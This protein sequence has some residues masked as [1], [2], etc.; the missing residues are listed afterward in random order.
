M[1]LAELTR[2]LLLGLAPLIAGGALARLGEASVDE[3]AQLLARTRERLGRWLAGRKAAEAALALYE[4]EPNDEAHRI[5]LERQIVARVQNDPAAS[6]ELQALVDELQ[7]LRGS[8]SGSSG[9]SQTFGDN[10]NI[11]VNV[12]GNAQGPITLGPVDQRRFTLPPG[13]AHSPTRPTFHAPAAQSADL[14]TLSSDGVH[15]THGYALLIGVGHYA[16]S[17]LSVPATANDAEQLAGLLR[18]QQAAAYL[19]ERVVVLRDAAA[20]RAAI[21]KALDELAMQSARDPKATVLVFFAG[22]GIQEGNS[23]YLLPHDYR[24]AALASSAISASDFSERLRVPAD[25]A[26]RLLVLLNC[27]HAG[28]VSDSVLSAA[29]EPAPSAPPSSFL[30]PLVE[31]GGRVVISSSRAAERSGTWA[32]ETV[33]GQQLLAALRGAAPG[34]SAGIGVLELFAYLS[35]NVPQAARAITDPHTGKALEQHP[36]LYAQR[37]DHDFAIT[38]RPGQRRGGTMSAD[39]AMVIQRLAELEYQLAVYPNEQSAPLEL[40]AKRDQL[41]SMMK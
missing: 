6:A 9:N 20:T 15:F 8:S 5:P 19:P 11:G 26:A 25:R 36:L 2:Q 13:P 12:A 16:H 29:S 33:F 38:L 17:P 34:Q 24:P 18:E 14:A 41:L 35:K 4:A 40:I 39:L 21:L 23:Y 7:R 31:G 27:C 37:L 32:T 10:T 3:S 28:G 22:H 30:D 1:E